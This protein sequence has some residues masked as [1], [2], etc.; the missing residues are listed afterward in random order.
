MQNASIKAQLAVLTAVGLIVGV[1]AAFVGTA[2]SDAVTAVGAGTAT[3]G[4]TLKAVALAALPIAA[5]LL[6]ITF[7]WRM[8]RRFVKV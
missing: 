2:D 3:L 1:G 4:D 5:G 8:A 6:A 7:G